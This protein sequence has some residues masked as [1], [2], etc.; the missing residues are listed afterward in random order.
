MY[1]EPRVLSMLL[2]L[3][4]P[5]MSDAFFRAVFPLLHSDHHHSTSPLPRII[6]TSNLAPADQLGL[7]MST[8]ARPEIP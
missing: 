7:R 2:Q 4:I 8:S 5:E 3:L 6:P 1:G